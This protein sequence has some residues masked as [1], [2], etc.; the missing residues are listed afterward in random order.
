MTFRRMITVSLPVLAL[1]AWQDSLSTLKLTREAFESNITRYVQ[2]LPNNADG[3]PTQPFISRPAAQAFLALPDATRAALTKELGAAAKAFVMSP[4]FAASYDAYLKNSRNAVNHGLTV[5]DTAAEMNAATKAGNYKAMEA[6]SK[7]MMR[8][9]YRQSVQN[10]LKSLGNYDKTT[11]PMMADAEIG[12]MAM[13]EPSTPAEKAAQAKAKTM[14]AE[15]KKLAATDLEKARATYKAALMLAGGFGSEADVTASED[16]G[17][18]LEQ[19]KNYNQAA[20]R[21]LLKKKLQQFVAIARTVDFSAQT[22]GPRKA[23][24]NPAYERK[25]NLWKMLYRLGPGSTNAA[26]AIAQSWATEL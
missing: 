9:A 8:D 17:K 3:D 13:A 1:W 20:L 7:N 12:M 11:L 26:V 25:P 24:V 10:S 2:S 18:K 5:K 21:P 14:L 4:A 16:A 6:A 19:Q 23:F 22:Q 15:A